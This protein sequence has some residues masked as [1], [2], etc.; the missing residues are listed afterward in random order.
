MM[1]HRMLLVGENV[2]SF[3]LNAIKNGLKEKGYDV[4]SVEPKLNDLNNLKEKPTHVLIYAGEFIDTAKDAMVFLRD[5]CIEHELRAS[6]VGYQEEVET[7]KKLFPSENIGHIFERPLNVKDLIAKME[8]DAEKAEWDE[9]KKHILVIDDSGTML[10]T[11]KSW[12]SEKYKVSIASSATMAI[13]FL[14]S[15]KPDLILLDYEMPVCNGPQFLEMIKSEQATRDI[16]VIFLTAKGDR[17]SVEKVLSLKPA[18]YLL[19]TMTPGDIL[20]N[21]DDFFEKQKKV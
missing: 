20:K 9:Q 14:A 4:I 16:P 7:I 21:I 10:R 13:T 19:K 17:E 3:I 6:I 5:Y 18:G 1:T 12:L 8:E 15:N 2:S 11:I